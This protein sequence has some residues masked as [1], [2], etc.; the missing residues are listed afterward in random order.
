MVAKA[1]DL[2]ELGHKHDPLKP[3][4]TDLHDNVTSFSDR[5]EALRERIE[6]ASRLHHLLTIQMQDESILQEIT[7]L[8]DTLKT[9]SL[10]ERCREIIKKATS[11]LIFSRALQSGPW[12][13]GLDILQPVLKES[14]CDRGSPKLEDDE[15]DTSKKADSGLGGCERCENMVKLTR[16]CSCQSIDE[17]NNTCGKR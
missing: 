5:L 9:P 4:L 6:G 13:G 12:E 14:F 15:E 10:M 2:M 16:T 11:Q 7:R 8:A 1:K 17:G 3:L